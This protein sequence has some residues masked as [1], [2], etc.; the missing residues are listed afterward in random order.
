MKQKTPPPKTANT[1]E[2]FDPVTVGRLIFPNPREAD[3]YGLVALGGDYRPEMLLAAYANGIFPWP[4]EDL[5]FSWF[6]PDPR[7]L[8]HPMDFHTSRSLRKTLRRRRFRRLS[9]R[10]SSRWL[11]AVRLP[12]E[13]GM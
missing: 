1:E 5:P 13:P 2:R 9:T 7:M 10:R 4:S 6:S 12:P 11:M 3:E 8:L